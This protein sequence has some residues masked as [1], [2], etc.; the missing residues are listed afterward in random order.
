MDA[1]TQTVTALES[2]ELPLVMASDSALEGYGRLVEDPEAVDIEIVTWPAQGWRPVDPG[3][4]DEGGTTEGLFEFWWRDGVLHGRNEAVGDQYELAWR[5]QDGRA[6][7]RHANY[8][9][10]G[11]QLFFPLD[12]GPF[13][14]PLALP[15]DDVKPTDFVA[16]RFEGGCGL[17]IHPGVWHEAVIPLA[18]RARFFDKQGRVHARISCEFDREFGCSLAV[19]LDLS[20]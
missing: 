18:E 4:G 17:Y 5:R 19:P 9:P 12:P 15:G 3:T 16:F 13:V 8:H 2:V 7:I 14:V 10:D 20:L 1:A 6:L 11:G